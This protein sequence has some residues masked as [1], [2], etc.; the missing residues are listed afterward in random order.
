MTKSQ[1][2]QIINEVTHIFK[3]K[4]WFNGAGFPEGDRLI[5]AYNYYPAFEL[6]E[7]RTALSKLVV[8]YELKDIRV[9]LP[10]SQKDDQPPYIK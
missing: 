2:Q 4:Q 8:E 10:G 1:K 3:N 9:I 5:I 6:V 7:V